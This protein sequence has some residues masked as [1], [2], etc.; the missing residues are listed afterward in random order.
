MKAL[1]PAHHSDLVSLSF[2][3]L[4]AMAQLNPFHEMLRLHLKLATKPFSWR[5]GRASK[6]KGQTTGDDHTA[7][8][9]RLGNFTFMPLSSP[10]GARP[11]EQKKNPSLTQWLAHAQSEKPSSSQHQPNPHSTPQPPARSLKEKTSQISFHNVTAY[12]PLT[13]PSNNNSTYASQPAKNSR[14]LTPTRSDKSPNHPQPAV[15]KTSC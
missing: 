6:E 3:Y 11:T 10:P 4:G 7:I 15:S 5:E 12:H 8:G 2:S 14:I 13:P 1:L 9:N